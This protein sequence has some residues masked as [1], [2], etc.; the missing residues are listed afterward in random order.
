MGKNYPMAGEP[1]HDP[2]QATTKNKRAFTTVYSNEGLYEMG[3]PHLFYRG[4]G[5]P[6]HPRG[7]PISESELVAHLLRLHHRRF[8]QD[9]S[10]LF[11]AH[12]VIQRRTVCGVTSSLEETENLI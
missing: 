11:F 6:S 3:F 10:F 8:C 5:G 12:S 4:T 7:R 2:E 1:G 9:A